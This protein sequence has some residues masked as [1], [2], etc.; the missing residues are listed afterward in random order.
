[1]G[2][3][4]INYNTGAGNKTIKGTLEEA[5][6]T[7]KNNATYTQENITIKD[8]KNNLIATLR[9]Y[10]VSPEVDQVDEQDIAVRFGDFGY[11]VVEIY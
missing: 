5:I 8:E 1:M 6:E 7:A 4:Y 2:K 11:Y 9:W 3:Y 10:G